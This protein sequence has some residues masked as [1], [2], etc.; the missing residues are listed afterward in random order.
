ML[1]HNWVV[2]YVMLS[3]DKCYVYC[4]C[5]YSLLAVSY[6]NVTVQYLS[7]FVSHLSH[8]RRHCLSLGGGD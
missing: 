5:A 4:Y 8:A 3:Q 1:L 2:L 7:S 6:V